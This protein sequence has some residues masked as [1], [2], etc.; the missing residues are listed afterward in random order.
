MPRPKPRAAHPANHPASNGSSA[1][2]IDGRF[3]LN[4]VRRH[5]KWIVP[6]GLVLAIL[7]AGAVYTVV[8]PVFEAAAWLRV[9]ET[10]PFLAFESQERPE[11]YIKTQVEL[12]RSPVVLGPAVVGAGLVET[13]GPE[14]NRH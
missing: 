10:A 2:A 8:D 9:D 14:K 11:G 3:L 13:A 7:A 1:N 5:W 12:L 4:V 6:V